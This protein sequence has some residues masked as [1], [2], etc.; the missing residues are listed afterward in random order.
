MW[1]LRQIGHI[2]PI[3]VWIKE[4]E[5]NENK[6]N[7]LVPAANQTLP[8]TAYQFRHFGQKVTLFVLQQ[9]DFTCI[10]NQ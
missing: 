2:Y 7:S 9:I 3:A 4:R 8:N 10:Y 1:D 5:Q 6:A